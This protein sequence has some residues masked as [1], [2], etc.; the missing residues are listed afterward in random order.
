MLMAA[1][2]PSLGKCP[3]S[4]EVADSMKIP[5]SW[6]EKL[7]DSKGLP[8]VTKIEGKL[9]A[10][11]GTGTMVIPAPLAVEALM[12]RVRKGKLATISELRA[13]LAK[14]HGVDIACPITTGM[15]SW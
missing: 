13:A 14:Q 11:W 9:S 5:K 12:R 1:W 2:I 4:D 7:A 6:C 3:I 15:F 10:R 8:K